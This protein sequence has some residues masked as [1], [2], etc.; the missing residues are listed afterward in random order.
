VHHLLGIFVELIRVLSSLK[1]LLINGSIPK[2]SI[3][4]VAR[5][6]L[7]ITGLMQGISS[8]GLGSKFTCGACH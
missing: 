6:R 4:Q 2:C 7:T 5:K 3:V 1:S 8:M